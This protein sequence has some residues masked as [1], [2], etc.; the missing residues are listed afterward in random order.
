MSSI[1]I[2]PPLPLNIESRELIEKRKKELNTKSKNIKYI[3]LQN[4]GSTCYLNSLIQSLFMTP[5]FRFNIFQWKYDI[6]LHGNSKDCIPF[7]LQ[8]LFYRLQY[9]I[10]KIEKTIDLT[11]SFQWNNNEVYIQQDIEEL[12]RVLFEAIEISIGTFDNFINEL[13]RGNC[14]SIIQC[15]ECNNKSI[16]QDTFLDLSLPIMNIFE[17]IHNKSL[18]MA[19][20]NF[21]KP[22]RLEKDNQYFCSKCNKKVDADKYM[23]FE[24]FP[25]ILFIQLGRFYYDFQIDS[26]NKLHNK[27]PFPLILNCNKYLKDY[28]DII[29]NSNEDENDN[30]C[31]Q[32]SEEII[33]NY[34]KEG[35][36][37]YEL[38]SIVIQS[39]TANGG[40]YFAYIKSFEDNKWYNFNDSNVSEITTDN[41][42]NVFGN[43]NLINKNYS[44]STTA[45]CLMYR[46]ISKNDKVY[47]IEDMKVDDNLI[48]ML[49]EENEEIIK[50]E[51]EREEKISQINIT[52]FKDNIKKIISIKRTS[53]FELLKEKLIKEFNLN[54]EESQKF[55]I[56]EYNSMYKKG[57]EYIEAA[58]NDT[59][60]QIYISSYKHYSI[61]L[62]DNNGNFPIYDPTLIEL[63]IHLFNDTIDSDTPIEKYPNNTIK[64]STN[65]KMKDLPIEICKS[66]NLD[67]NTKIFVLRRNDF[68]F[69]I[70]VT[71]TQI[72]NKYLYSDDDIYLKNLSQR[73]DLFI[74][75][76]ENISMSN[77]NWMKIFKKQKGK[78]TIKF[79]TLDDLSNFSNQIIV[80]KFDTIK[81]IKERLC[82]TLSYNPNEIIIKKGGKNGEELFEL[83]NTL[84][85]YLKGDKEFVIY[86]EKGNPLKENQLIINVCMCLYDYEKFNIF[87][88]KIEDISKI[89]IDNDK[90]ILDLKKEILN[91]CNLPFQEDDNNIIIIRNLIAGRPGKI[92]LDNTII[93]NLDFVNEM[94]IV[95][96]N[97]QKDLIDFSLIENKN[98]SDDE[99]IQLTL[100]YFN[101]SNWNLSPPIEILINYSESIKSI[102]KIILKYFPEI[103]KE[104]NIQIIKIKFNIYLDEIMKME[105]IDLI[106]YENSSLDKYP[107]IIKNNG[108]V[109]II[110]DKSKEIG[111]IND[112]IKKKYFKPEDKKNIPPPPDI[113]LI[114]SNSN[115]NRVK[116]MIKLFEN[117]EFDLVTKTY[118]N[119]EYK[120]KRERP[121]EKGIVIKVKKIGEEEEKKEEDKK[122]NEKKEGV[123]NDEEKKNNEV[124]V[125]EKKNEENKINN[126]NKV[127]ND[128]FDEIPPDIFDDNEINIEPLI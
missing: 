119:V 113:N 116:N 29:Y 99:I 52:F 7:Q 35:P 104:E 40:H 16:N 10:R 111:E 43:D 120:T 75:I 81:E 73:G 115:N 126:N 8:K 90:S 97:I 84:S 30:F 44:T 20:M 118:K 110:K 18:G 98:Y 96:Q 13:Y 72:E 109:L 71:Y 125:E 80:N 21:I 47:T 121:K 112:E 55:K 88:Y 9:P 28:K 105:F 12:C 106:E 56:R 64:I 38:F 15:L 68:G 45:Y 102:E 87:P 82:E 51:K 22:E 108:Y 32:Y 14:Q 128:I 100:R 1:P 11:K 33:N 62:P 34:L 92:Y 107:F 66:L 54:D 86:L 23:K 5:E 39:G 27:V 94:K 36:N 122:E 61:Q 85:N 70:E 46:K 31:I 3:G 103:S 53:T 50:K 74:E 58:D 63:N 49:K 48:E 67:L 37:V 59:L 95:V 26:R 101:I 76:G 123:L 65:S 77:S 6:N 60:E 93:K 114:N 69:G 4:Q 91:K 117:G 78:I 41:I 83:D 57:L 127:T 19:L 124:K 42:I 25:K 89:I 17:G 79:N 2:P 24:K